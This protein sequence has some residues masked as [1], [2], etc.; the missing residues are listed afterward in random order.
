MTRYAGHF[1]CPISSFTYSNTNSAN[2]FKT[3]KNHFIF[4][5]QTKYQRIII[6]LFSL[7]ETLYKTSIRTKIKGARTSLKNTKNTLI[8]KYLHLIHILPLFNPL[9]N[10]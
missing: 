10:Y 5:Q 8:V 2:L 4:L 3:V 1:F 7:Y 6:K 9:I